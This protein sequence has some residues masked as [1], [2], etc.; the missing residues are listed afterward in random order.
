MPQAFLQRLLQN[1]QGGL[2]GRQKPSPHPLCQAVKWASWPW[3]PAH[4]L[5]SPIIK[6]KAGMPK[7]GVR[8]LCSLSARVMGMRGRE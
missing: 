7:K 6:V 3:E 2:S 5:L 1:D 4:T 8:T